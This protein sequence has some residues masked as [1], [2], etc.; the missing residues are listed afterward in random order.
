MK[1]RKK[2]KLC[3]QCNGVNPISA[4]HCAYCGAVLAIDLE[5]EISLDQRAQTPSS[6]QYNKN[7]VT[8]F[9]AVRPPA[10]NP[11][12]LKMPP[13]VYTANVKPLSSEPA[14][15]FST[16]NPFE[17][18]KEK[19]NQAST[20]ISKPLYSVFDQPQNQTDHYR[21]NELS[22]EKGSSSPES[23]S[24]KLTKIVQIKAFIKN[25]KEDCLRSRKDDSFTYS[26]LLQVGI[27]CSLMLAALSLLTFIFSYEG[28]I[29]LVWSAY[30]WPWLGASA[31][32]LFGLS[33]R[34]KQ[35]LE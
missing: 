7:Q 4:S 12:D 25:L 32:I 20:E 10:N 21:S 23:S 8:S 1:T 9:E 30:L 6:N 26:L 13:P 5:E 17:S 28:K 11:S 35:P 18:K 15:P 2:T 27:N 22:P 16:H 33:W 29:V 19:I 31:L 14:A 34:I 24:N 3:L